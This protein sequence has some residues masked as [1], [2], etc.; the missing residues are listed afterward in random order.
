MCIRDSRRLRRL[1]LRHYRFLRWRRSDYLGDFHVF[2]SGLDRDDGSLL[3]LC[4]FRFA[5]RQD[6][7]FDLNRQ[8]GRRGENCCIGRLG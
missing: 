1:G 7:L 5:H 6:R 8:I 4:Y 3:Q 2:S